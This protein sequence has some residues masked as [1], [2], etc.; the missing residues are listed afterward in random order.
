MPLTCYCSA[1]PHCL[2]HPAS[3]SCRHVLY[4]HLPHTVFCGTAASAEKCSRVYDHRTAQLQHSTATAQQAAVQQAAVQHSTAQHSTAA[5][6]HSCSTAQLQQ[7]SPA[8]WT[9]SRKSGPRCL[10]RLQ[11]QPWIC[12]SSPSQHRAL[13]ARYH[14]LVELQQLHCQAALWSCSVRTHLLT[15]DLFCDISA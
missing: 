1:A 8:V 2:S 5:A 9:G 3:R 4:R 11:P 15:A 7:S 6:Q 13:T 10:M 12:W 14:W